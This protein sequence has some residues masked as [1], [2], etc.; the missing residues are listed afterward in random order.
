MKTRRPNVKVTT[1][2]E[3]MSKGLGGGAATKG[4][5]DALTKAGA[6]PGKNSLEITENMV[7]LKGMLIGNAVSIVSRL[8]VKKLSVKMDGDTIEISTPSSV[9]NRMIAEGILHNQYTQKGIAPFKEEAVSVK[10]PKSGKKV[11]VKI[12]RRA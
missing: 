11:I 3:I 6:I 2:E 4:L 5:V 8:G 9:D 12:D 1:V 7:C 10:C